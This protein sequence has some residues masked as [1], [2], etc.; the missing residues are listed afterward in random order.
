[1]N[2]YD[3][4]QKV[5]AQFPARSEKFSLPLEE[6]RQN[7]WKHG[8]ENATRRVPG[9]MAQ[10]LGLDASV[11]VFEVSMNRTELCTG[12]MPGSVFLAPE[13]YQSASLD[14][15]MKSAMR[16]QSMLPG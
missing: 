6:L 9:G 12:A 3:V 2:S 14:D 16:V 7:E 15:L 5:F 8:F 4:M 1:M 10:A 11:A 13:G